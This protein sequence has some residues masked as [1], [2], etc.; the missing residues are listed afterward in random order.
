[1]QSQLIDVGFDRGY[2]F[3]SK[4]A[5]QEV[6]SK[7]VPVLRILVGIPAFNE[8]KTVGRVIER[9]R[10]ALPDAD[11]VVVD[12][13]SRD[14]TANVVRASQVCLISLPCNLGYSSVVETLLRYSARHDYDALA[15]I[16]ADGQHD[17]E[18]LPVLL[19][20]FG[21]SDCDMLIGSRYVEAPSYSDAPLGRQ[22]GMKLFSYLTRLLTGKRIF[23]TTSG[24][25]VIGRRAAVHL[26][27]WK[28]VD[29]HAEAIIY[30]L[31]TG[32]SVEEYPITVHEREH[33]ESMY[34]FISHLW[35]PLTVMLMIAIS[36]LHVTLNRYN[37]NKL[38]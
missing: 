30:L 21:S 13:G 18:C 7:K 5:T 25:K 16:D 28:F 23:D 35:Y 27:D 8:E 2:T 15:L 19:R 34:S 31:W 1:M 14:G 11:V 17:P 4:L 6:L 24:M 20:A 29:F 10:A 32:Y 37:R 22:L 9:T 12:D 26:L 33:G 36:G 38:A 3:A